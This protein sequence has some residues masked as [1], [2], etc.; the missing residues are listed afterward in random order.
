MVVECTRFS[1]KK[2]PKLTNLWLTNLIKEY[3]GNLGSNPRRIREIWDISL[4]FGQIGQRI[5]VRYWAIYDIKKDNSIAN[6]RNQKSSDLDKNKL[7]NRSLKLGE[8]LY[9]END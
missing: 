1:V 9:R 5:E 8:N 2:S 3:N 7:S 6:P 4:K